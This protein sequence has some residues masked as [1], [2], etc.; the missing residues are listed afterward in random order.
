MP[1]LESRTRDNY[2]MPLNETQFLEIPP[3][4]PQDTINKHG[5]F[6]IKTFKWIYDHISKNQLKS[7]ILLKFW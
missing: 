5:L 3:K 4:D 6:E 1:R 2:R 7:R